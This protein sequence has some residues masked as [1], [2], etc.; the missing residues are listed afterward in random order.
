[1]S[2]TVIPLLLPLKVSCHCQTQR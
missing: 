1:M 2:L